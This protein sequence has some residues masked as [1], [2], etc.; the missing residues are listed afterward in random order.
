[1]FSDPI[2]SHCIRAAT[3]RLMW[4]EVGTRILPPTFY[5]HNIPSRA[6]DSSAQMDYLEPPNRP[7][8]KR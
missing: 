2:I 1:M 7:E 5:N 8:G 6:Y 3:S 4:S